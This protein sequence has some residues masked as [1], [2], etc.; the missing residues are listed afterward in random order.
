MAE[1][2]CHL[3][4]AYIII[5]KFAGRLRENA[6]KQKRNQDLMVWEIFQLFQ[7]AKF[8]KI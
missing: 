7:I 4:K 1:I 6:I 5:S 3:G 8:A 2:V